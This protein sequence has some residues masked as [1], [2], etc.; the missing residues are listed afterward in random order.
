MDNRADLSEKNSE[1]DENVRQ[2]AFDIKSILTGEF[3][4]TPRSRFLKTW[5]FLERKPIEEISQIAESF[6]KQ[7]TKERE[8]SP[9]K[10]LLLEV[11]TKL[12]QLYS[13]RIHKLIKEKTE[14]EIAEGAGILLALF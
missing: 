8:L 12:P 7:F 4:S 13:E 11:E 6:Q 5:D 10:S 9:L 3:G 1:P 2:D 14:S